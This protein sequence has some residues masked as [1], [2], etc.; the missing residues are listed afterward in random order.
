MQIQKRG[1]YTKQP[2]RWVVID[3][4]LGEVSLFTMLDEVNRRLKGYER[5]LSERNTLERQ[6][7]V[8]ALSINTLNQVIT[9]LRH[10]DDI[11]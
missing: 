11:I 10:G 6:N 1:N 7:Q 5:L 3:K 8:Q 4:E 2:E 9:K